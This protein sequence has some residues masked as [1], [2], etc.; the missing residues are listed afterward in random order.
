MKDVN[1]THVKKPSRLF[2][3]RDYLNKGNNSQVQ[4]VFAD[5]LAKQGLTRE[6]V[7]ATERKLA[8]FANTMDSLVRIPFTQ[9]GIGADAALS[10][11]PIAG[12]VAGL[13]LTGYAFILGRQLG[14]P[15]SKMTPAIKLAFIDMVVGVVPAVGTLLDIFIRPSRKT[16]TI[17]HQHLQDEYGIDDTMHL[18]RPFLHESLENKQQN[19]KLWRNPVVAWLHLR[20]PD[21]LGI[22]VLLL[23]GWLMWS[24]GSWVLGM[25]DRNTGF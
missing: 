4:Q 7:I 16:L 17:V 24:V 19:S 14:V 13:I 10:T 2:G 6:Q 5:N 23:L 15:V 8:K 18:Q 9:Q 21:I 22:I 12:D 11:V 20:I 3:G 25:F 1:S